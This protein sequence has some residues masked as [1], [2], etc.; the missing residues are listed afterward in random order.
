MN[1]EKVGDLISP[2]KAT[3]FEETTVHHPKKKNKK[4]RRKRTTK[5][6]WKKVLSDQTAPLHSIPLEK[7]V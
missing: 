7:A 4:K 5:L 3:P 1:T 6:T 2:T